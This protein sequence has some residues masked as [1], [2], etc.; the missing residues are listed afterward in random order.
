MNLS[1]NG[2]KLVE[3]LEWDSVAGR[4]LSVMGY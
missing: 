2:V 1:F 4:P 3:M